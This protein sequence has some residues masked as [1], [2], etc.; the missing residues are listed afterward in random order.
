MTCKKCKHGFCWLCLGDESTHRKG[1]GHFDPCSG[2]AE[3]NRKIQ[4]KK[5]TKVIDK[6]AKE[7]ADKR[8]EVRLEHYK[9]RFIAHQSSLRFA[10]RTATHQRK[11]A[12][13]LVE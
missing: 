9:T 8:E 4:A 12:E 2:F 11:F 7:A 3:A 10:T 1:G 5:S 13:L 6:A